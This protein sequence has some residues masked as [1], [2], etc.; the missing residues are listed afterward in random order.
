[1]YGINYQLQI[2]HLTQLIVL[3]IRCSHVRALLLTLQDYTMIGWL[4][5]HCLMAHRHIRPCRANDAGDSSY[6]KNLKSLN[7]ELPR[8]KE[9]E[10]K[11]IN[12][13]TVSKPIPYSG[14]YIMLQLLQNKHSD[15]STISCAN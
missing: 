15:L 7:M 10:P 6:I 9:I 2:L 3:K 5:V 12:E 8:A 11:P 4:V 13:I 14:F 1:M